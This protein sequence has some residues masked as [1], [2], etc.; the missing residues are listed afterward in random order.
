MK[1]NLDLKTLVMIVSTACVLAGFY[2]T[3]QAR[4]D[5]V[6][7][8]VQDLQEDTARLDKMVKSLKKAR[9]K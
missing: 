2:Y 3:T 1:F 4:L 8:H 5:A 9:R 6:E 7:H